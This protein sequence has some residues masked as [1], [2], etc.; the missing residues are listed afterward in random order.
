MGTIANVKRQGSNRSIVP[1]RC[2]KLGVATVRV[3]LLIAIAVLCDS[4][5]CF[6]AESGSV[7]APAAMGAPRVIW[8]TFVGKSADT[9]AAADAKR[10]ITASQDG[11]VS[12][13]S[14]T[15]GKPLWT[16]QPKSRPSSMPLLTDTA[17]YLGF[18]DGLVCA[19]DA[20]TGKTRWTFQTGQQIVGRPAL[21]G[22]RLL[23]GSYDTHL[24]CLAADTGKELWNFTTTAQVHAAPLVVGDIVIIGGCDGHLHAV[25]LASGQERWSVDAGGPVGASPIVHDQQIFAASMSSTILSTDL[26]GKLLWSVSPME[27]R[28]PVTTSPAISGGRLAVAADDGQVLMLNPADGKVLASGKVPGKPTTG[29]VFLNDQLLVGVDDGRIYVIDPTTGKQTSRITLGGNPLSIIRI[30]Q[31][32]IS[33]ASD[34]S[35]WL[36][37]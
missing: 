27:E 17:V 5:P 21:A 30:D 32:I 26:A 20:E 1:V 34:G 35:V 13:C 3:G 23:V 24:Y 33:N 22:N 25:D 8:R 12:A 31:G 6:A 15:D 11:S 18:A 37:K 28:A 7:T 2:L 29:L 16:I 14:P 9:P 36:L 10:I 4:V 19:L